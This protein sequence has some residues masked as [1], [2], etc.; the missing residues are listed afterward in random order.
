MKRFIIAVLILSLSFAVHAQIQLIEPRMVKKAE[1]GDASAQFELGKSYYALEEYEK[2]A[3]LFMKSAGQGHVQSQYMMAVLYMQGRGVGRDFTKAAEWF[4]AAAGQGDAKSQ[5][6]LG[7]LYCNGYG[8]PQDYAAARWWLKKAADQDLPSAQRDLAELYLSGKGGERDYAAAMEYFTKAA[9][10]NDPIAMHKAGYMYQKGY[11]VALSYESAIM[12]YKKSASAGY[13]AAANSI[14]MIYMEV[15]GDYNT[16]A[17][18]FI[19]G[20]KLGDLSG[21]KDMGLALI[22]ESDPVNGCVWIY[23]SGDSKLSA[24]CNTKLSTGEQVIVKEKIS[25]I[26]KRHPEL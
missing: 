17:G 21:L 19:T 3:A 15:S 18:W 26:K 5:N 16:A 24:H 4:A 14:G 7:L 6:N 2:C 8:V 25:E 23:L 20:A 13:A 9:G 1:A 12:W 11:G 22:S 10:H